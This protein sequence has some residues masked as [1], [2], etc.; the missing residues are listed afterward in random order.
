MI[1]DVRNGLV[2]HHQWSGRVRRW[3][4]GCRP[5]GRRWL[6]PQVSTSMV[7]RWCREGVMA[8]KGRGRT[9]EIDEDSL[10]GLA[11]SRRA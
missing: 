8:A 2:L 6:R 9:W 3:T 5:G 11:L 4:R 7:R 10:V 1:T